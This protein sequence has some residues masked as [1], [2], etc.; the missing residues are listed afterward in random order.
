MT[1]RSHDAFSFASL[2]T[3]AVYYPPNSLSFS[4][5]G[6]SLIGN[7]VGGLLPDLDQAS[8]RLWD[9]LPAG[10]IVGRFGRKLFLSHRTLSHSILGG[11]LLYRILEELLPRILNPSFI[12][13]NLVIFSMMIGYLAHLL[14]DSLTE[15]GIPLFFPFKIMLGFPPIP[16]WRIKTGGWFEK[17]LIFPGLVVYLV[18]FSIVNQ[19]VLVK[20]LRL[21]VK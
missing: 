7:I 13:V 3:L 20:I 8:N 14:A 2:L 9:L 16:S 18:W 12:N 17:L 1:S 6:V 19:A 15:E 10:N 5:L 11:Y 21:M 4:T